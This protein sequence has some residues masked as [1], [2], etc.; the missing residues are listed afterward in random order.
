MLSGWSLSVRT[1]HIPD[2]SHR[3]LL[4]RRSPA[5][6]TILF[7]VIVISLS[8]GFI[9]IAEPAYFIFSAFSL[10]IGLISVLTVT[11]MCVRTYGVVVSPVTKRRLSP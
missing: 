1:A 10:A 5:A 3:G 11:L 8:V 9:A 4:K 7:S 6:T 2:T